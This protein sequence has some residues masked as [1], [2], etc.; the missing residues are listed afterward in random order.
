MIDPGVRALLGSA[1]SL[2][3]SAVPITPGLTPIGDQ[4][5]VGPVTASNRD[6]G[7]GLFN[8]VAF[9]I[10]TQTVGNLEIDLVDG[11]LAG[12]RIT[13]QMPAS[14]GAVETI[15]KDA[16]GAVT[17]VTL[18]PGAAVAPSAEL[19]WDGAAWQ[20]VFYGPGAT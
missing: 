11:L 19:M 1:Q 10:A 15:V 3:F 9:K 4:A 17:I 13:L 18:T 2:D 16:A 6:G 5:G 20:V 7:G 12:E 14:A 8:G